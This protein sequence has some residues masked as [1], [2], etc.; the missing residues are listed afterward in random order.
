[1]RK[2]IVVVDRK[3][4]RQR[5][6]RNGPREDRGDGELMHVTHP[7]QIPSYT[8]RHSTKLRFVSSAAFD[9]VITWQNL[10][11]TILVAATATTGFDVFE[12]VKIRFVEVWAA[13]LLGSA[14]S[15][16]VAFAG[17]TAGQVGDQKI[18][19][20]TSMG[21]QPAHVKA[22]P[23]RKSLASDFQSSGATNAFTLTVPAGAVIDV[24]L[25][26][27]GIFA[28]AKAAQNA[29]V[30]ATAGAFYVRGLDGLAVAST[31]LVPV[32][33]AADQI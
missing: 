3:I 16:S 13:P 12:T 23:D 26:F 14:V 29:L 20:D 15:V 19:T 1:M 5:N 2:Q 25:T 9:T 33:R 22:R 4:S 18:H 27:I 21:V 10:L 8:L 24:A 32:I 28:S 30:A 17:L 6:Q 11:D 7:P 31:Q